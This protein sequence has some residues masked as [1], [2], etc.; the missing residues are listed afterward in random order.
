MDIRIIQQDNETLH[1]EIHCRQITDE[2]RRL[3]AHIGLFRHTLQ[4]KKEQE[5]CM[6]ATGN[7]LYFESVDNRTFVYTSKDVLEVRQKLYELED[8]LSEKDFIRISKS[9]I[10]NINQIVSLK[11][12]L[13][14]TLLATM[15]NGERL[16][17]SRKYVPDVKRLLSL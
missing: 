12:E 17:V 16:S 10:V 4:A 5:T 14:R 15:R 7:I 8:I 2:V 6:V 9:V 11:P 3:K 1:V 13:N